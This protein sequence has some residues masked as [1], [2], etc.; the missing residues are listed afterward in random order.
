MKIGSFDLN[1]METIFIVLNSDIVK[2]E[3]ILI[4]ENIKSIFLYAVDGKAFLS[5]YCTDEDSSLLITV[6]Y[7]VNP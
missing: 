7:T 3:W 1:T 4:D 6:L 5:R 2:V